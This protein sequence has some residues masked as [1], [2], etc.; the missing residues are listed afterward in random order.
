MVVDRRLDFTKPWPEEEEELPTEPRMPALADAIRVLSLLIGPHFTGPM[1]L[2]FKN[3]DF[4]HIELPPEVKTKKE[5][6]L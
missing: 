6:G 2:H 4:Q 1:V 5:L 3:G